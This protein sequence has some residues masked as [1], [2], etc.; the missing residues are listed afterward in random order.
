[1]ADT[2]Y[3]FEVNG[4]DS[5]QVQTAID[6]ITGLDQ[7]GVTMKGFEHTAAAGN[8][9]IGQDVFRGDV[10]G[11]DV[12]GMQTRIRNKVFQQLGRYPDL[13]ENPQ[14]PLVGFRNAYQTYGDDI[15]NRAD[16]KTAVYAAW[17]AAGGMT[18]G[19]SHTLWSWMRDKGFYTK[20]ALKDWLN[21]TP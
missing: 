10:G 2:Y 7:T 19:D 12:S 17:K 14:S 11:P 20:K 3:R 1:M 9:G 21:E 6:W 13:E 18:P 8:P 5:S 4:I 15:N 16:L